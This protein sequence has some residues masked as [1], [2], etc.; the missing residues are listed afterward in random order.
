MVTTSTPDI[1]QVR[2]TELDE[3]LNG[4]A[5]ADN[6]EG[7]AGDDAIGGWEG[8]D[9]LYGGD[10]DDILDGGDGN[11]ILYGG[12]GNDTFRVSL[13]E[14]DMDT[15]QDFT[16]DN[17]ININNYRDKVVGGAMPIPG[18]G[19]AVPADSSE[20]PEPPEPNIDDIIA[21]LAGQNV[22]Y[23]VQ[24]G[25]TLFTHNGDEFLILEGY[26]ATLTVDNIEIH[27]V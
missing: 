12:D 2:G 10:D 24:G 14:E 8:N 6:I 3:I 9:T 13:G 21:E 27:F 16:A 1:N 18:G 25:N 15:V 5:D 23:T 7:G 11:D 22:E 20:P 17:I 26:T 4:S 19:T